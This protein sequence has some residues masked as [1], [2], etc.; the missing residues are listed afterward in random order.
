MLT[1]FMILSFASISGM[2]DIHGQP[3]STLVLAISQ[4]ITDLRQRSA[5]LQ[6]IVQ[7]TQRD[8]EATLSEVVRSRTEAEAQQAKELH[9]K[10]IKWLSLTDPSS[11]H[12]ASRKKHQSTT[13][14]GC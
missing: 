4:G 13:E 9:R 6:S 1:S 11:N 7:T 5:L 8:A 10:V 2:S 12:L 3:Y 14:D